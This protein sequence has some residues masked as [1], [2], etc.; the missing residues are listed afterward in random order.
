MDL[1]KLEFNHAHHNTNV[2]CNHLVHNASVQ[3]S[4]RYKKAALISNIHNIAPD[5]DVVTA[6]DAAVLIY[7][8][9]LQAYTLSLHMMIFR[10]SIYKHFLDL[11]VFVDFDKEG[12]LHSSGA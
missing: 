3:C 5:I 9:S 2:S 12:V 8:I 6:Y 1:A 11:G 4:F 7:I 10:R